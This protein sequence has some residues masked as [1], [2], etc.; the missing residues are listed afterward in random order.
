[1]TLNVRE[2]LK[3]VI[4]WIFQRIFITRNNKSRRA[5]QSTIQPQ[6]SNIE[7]KTRR[8]YNVQHNIQ[9]C[10]TNITEAPN[11]TTNAQVDDLQKKSKRSESYYA[12]K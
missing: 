7:Q 5:Q 9:N 1:M 10:N 12:R 8:K 2:F 11:R 4:F 3:K 6:R